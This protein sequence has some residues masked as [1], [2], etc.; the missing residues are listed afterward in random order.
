VRQILVPGELPLRRDGIPD[1]DSAQG[2]SVLQVRFG[3]VHRAAGLLRLSAAQ[4]QRP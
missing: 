2:F 4:T 1:G 3:V